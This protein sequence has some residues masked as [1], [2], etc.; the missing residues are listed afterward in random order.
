MS[1]LSRAAGAPAPAASAQTS[2]K[3]ISPLAA[4]RASAFLRD[5]AVWAAVL[6]ALAIR[7]GYN[8]ALHPGGHVPADFVIDEREYFGAAHVL[9]EGRGFTFFDTALWVRPPLFVAALALLFRL[10]G[11]GYVPILVFQSLLGAA[12]V[13]PLAFLAF[14]IRGIVAA[15]W[16]AFI[17]ALY[18]PLTLFAGLLLSETLFVLLFACS[19]V[20]LYETSRRAG[21]DSRQSYLW[22]AAAGLLLGLC[23]LTRGTALAF[24]PLAAA[25]LFVALRGNERNR[26]LA[27]A[28][29]VG[30]A[31]LALVP[32]T[33]RNYA[34]YGRIVVVDTTGGY[35]LWLAA[36][37][38]RD[39]LRMQAE[40]AAV[41]GPVAKQEYSYERAFGI[42]AADPGAFVA[43]GLKE[44]LDL[45]RPSFG[46]EERQVRGYTLGR[47]PGWHLGTLLLFDDLLFIAIVLLALAGL[48]FLPSHPLKSLTVLWVLLWVA[49]AFVFFAVTRFRLPMVAALMPWAGAALTIL[50]EPGWLSRS[51]ARGRSLAVTFAVCALAFLVVVLPSIDADDTLLGIARWGEQEP[52]RAAEGLLRQGD[53]PA[54]LEQY[55]RANQ[56]IADT[57]YGL[58]AARLQA[59]DSAGALALL[60]P[61][62]PEERFEPDIIRG[63]A[64]RMSGDLEAARALFNTRVVQVAGQEAVDWAWDHLRPAPVGR[65]ELGSGLDL[66]YVRGFHGPERDADGRTFRWLGQNGA[67]R[68]LTGNLELALMVNGWRPGGAAPATIKARGAGVDPAAAQTAVE[69]LPLA[70]EWSTILVFAGDEVELETNGFV[71]GGYDLRLLGVRTMTVAADRAS[72]RTID[73]AHR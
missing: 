34:A 50:R 8:L 28:L 24:L 49:M 19:L 37:G 22:A 36:Q 35:N 69:T 38:V 23:I 60:R 46:A 27:P 56:D 21:S 7:I 4:D 13:L 64:A 53:V 32:W 26:W 40:L 52:Y 66:G 72:T 20:A 16:T 43:K 30:I 3:V 1:K 57:R 42:I 2:T 15:R 41:E 68:G 47:V 44:S 17:T 70:D 11:T 31:V 5:G 14:R 71:P 39:E 63:E 73:E 25:W 10:I 29:V 67:V 58:A 6:L 9:A 62:D 61:D 33:M 55:A 51:I 59:L 12:A 45:W 18:L 65:V 48:L 54:A